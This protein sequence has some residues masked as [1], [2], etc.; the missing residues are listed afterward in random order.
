MSLLRSILLAIIVTGNSTVNA[1]FKLWLGDIK[2][3]DLYNFIYPS[4]SYLCY[5]ISIALSFPDFLKT[6]SSLCSIW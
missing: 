1:I 4:P 2:M 6:L 3:T 5:Q